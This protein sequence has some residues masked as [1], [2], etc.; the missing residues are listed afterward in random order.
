MPC[1]FCVVCTQD[2]V[3]ERVVLPVFVLISM[4]GINL[5]GKTALW[6]DSQRAGF[7]PLQSK[8]QR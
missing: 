7:I 8:Y 4:L 1:R 5:G 2:M 6:I 3:P